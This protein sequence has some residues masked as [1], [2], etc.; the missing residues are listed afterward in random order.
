VGQIRSRL[1]ALTEES[2]S[3][4]SVKKLPVFCNGKSVL[5]LWNS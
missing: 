5:R 4:F 2:H 3:N 1:K